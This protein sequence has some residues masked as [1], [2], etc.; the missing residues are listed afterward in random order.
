MDESN[1]AAT[2][3]RLWHFLHSSTEP[4]DIDDL[5]DVDLP[6]NEDDI[7]LSWFTPPISSPDLSSIPNTQRAPEIPL[8]PHIP[9]LAPGWTINDDYQLLHVHPTHNLSLQEARRIH[10]PE[11]SEVE[12]S[13]RYDYLKYHYSCPDQSIF[14]SNSLKIRDDLVDFLYPQGYPTTPVVFRDEP[15]LDHCYG[16]FPLHR[17]SGFVK[18]NHSAIPMIVFNAQDSSANTYHPDLV[19]L[20]TKLW[21]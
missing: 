17:V 21:S 11:R 6:S 8:E 7:E 19:Q 5:L 2:H 12:I 18:I 4:S 13:R 9:Q 1:G 14:L 16:I 10:F 3:D 15:I 20:V